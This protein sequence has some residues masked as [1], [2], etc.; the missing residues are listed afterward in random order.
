MEEDSREILSPL[1]VKPQI[2]KQFEYLEKVVSESQKRVDYTVAHDNDILKAIETV[3]RFLRKE[4]RVCYGGQAINALLPQEYKFYDP[5]YTIP[6]YDF[7]SPNPATDVDNLVAALEKE[8]FDNVNKKLGVHEGTIKVF[9]NFIPVADISMMHPNL[10]RIIQ[11]RAKS[12]NGILYCDQDFL[13][14][15][16]YL[17]LSRPRGEVSRWKKVYERLLLLNATFPIE[18]C[19]DEIHVGSIDRKDRK[20]ILE[21]CMSHK[22]VLASPEFIDLFETNHSRTHLDTLIKRG[23]PVIFFSSQAEIDGDDLKSILGKGVKVQATTTMTDQLFNFVS[24]KR[25]G[26]PLAI[27]FQEDA[28]HSYSILQVDTS[29]MRIA[30]PD[31]YLHLYYSL[32]IFGKKEKAFFETSM[33][34]LIKKLYAVLKKARNHPTEFIP[35]FGLKCSGKQKGIATLLHEKAK[36]TEKAKKTVRKTRTTYRRL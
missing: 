5:N 21:F 35:A 33:D 31:L 20:D 18:R 32:L 29:D 14:M 27:I 1:L 11:K 19:T 23:G 24:I 6:D 16:M 17:E 30:T 13:R 12:V 15:L 26:T 28:C 3:E 10:F 34:C 25:N 4:K 2:Q 36:R 9:V 8:G 22:R 7:F